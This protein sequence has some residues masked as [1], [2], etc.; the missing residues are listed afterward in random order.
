[1]VLERQHT[2][3]GLTGVESLHETYVCPAC[4]ARF[5]PSV[6]GRWKELG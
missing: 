1:L 3:R 2:S 4:D 5:Q 6:D